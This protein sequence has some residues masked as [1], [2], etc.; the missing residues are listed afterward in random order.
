MKETPRTKRDKESEVE[1]WAEERT[2]QCALCQH[3]DGVSSP[4]SMIKLDTAAERG[5]S[6]GLTG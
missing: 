6:L 1:K 2:A 4:A 3:E 5:G